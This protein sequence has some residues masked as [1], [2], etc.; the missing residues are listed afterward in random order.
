MTVHRVVVANA[1]GVSR[2]IESGRPPRSAEFAAPKGLEQNLIWCTPPLP[3][4]HHDGSDPTVSARTFVPQPG[5]T[6]FMVMTIPPDS[7]ASDPSFDP[8]VAAAELVKH[9]PGIAETFEPDNPGMHTTSTIDYDIVL[10]GELW[11]ELTDGEVRLTAGDVVVQH[12]TR[13][14]WRNKS[15]RPATVAF[16]LIGAQAAPKKAESE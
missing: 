13:H 9:A 14:A 2:V 3:T 16:I 4:V 6:S 15:D 5:G 7:V 10:D 12:G 11:L 8:A 1:D